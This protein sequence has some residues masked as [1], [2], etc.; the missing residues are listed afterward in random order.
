MSP[1]RRVLQI[2]IGDDGRARASAVPF[3]QLAP[4]A[5]QGL[6]ELRSNLQLRHELFAAWEQSISRGP[7]AY[8]ISEAELP[9]G[10][11]AQI[12]RDPHS[13]TPRLIVIW[14]EGMNDR[15]IIMAQALLRRNEM[16]EPEVTEPVT[17]SVWDDKAYRIQS[18]GSV[19]RKGI[20]NGQLFAQNGN[21]RSEIL[22][23]RVVNVPVTNFRQLGAVRFFVPE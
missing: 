11:V 12:I 18:R 20:M 1:N 10:A 5:Q 15:T 7:P 19:V 17:I 9:E 22:L 21:P 4:E 3:T 6:D 23:R 8:A 16:E 13:A 14:K 2:E